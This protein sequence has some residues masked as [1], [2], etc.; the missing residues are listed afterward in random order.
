MVGEI[1]FHLGDCKTGST[2][3]QK[4]LASGVVSCP[5]RS[6]AYPAKNNHNAV[7]TSMY[8][9]SE[10]KDVD[11]RFAELRKRVD[12][13]DADTVVISAEAFEFAA[14]DLMERM[15]ANYF[16]PWQGKIRF[17]SYVRPHSERLVSA[18]AERT[19]QGV[20]LGPMGELLSRF[21]QTG[22]L[23][24]TPRLE[25]WRSR[26]GEAYT[27]RPMIRSQLRDNDVVADFLDYLFEGREFQLGEVSI[28]NESLTIADLAAL[29]KI[30]AIIKQSGGPKLRAAQQ[31]MGWNFAMTLASV[32][33][34]GTTDKPRL[35]R[36][37]AERV[38]EV[39]REDARQLD[40]QFFEG[41]PMTTAL[42][43]APDKALD[44]PQALDAEAFFDAD[45]LR[46]LQGMGQFFGS[47]LSRKPE[48]MRQI[49]RP[50]KPK[51]VGGRTGKD[52]GLIK[53][54]S[55]PSSRA[56]ARTLKG[57]VRSGA[58]KS[59]RALARRLD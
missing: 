50:G 39:Y 19:K 23:H 22:L 52:V 24:Y 18:F 26:F 48:Q 17:I 14:P 21:E 1:V 54:Q 40:E 10:M 59:L 13:C 53:A 31:T 46:V 45:S 33:R 58:R 9:K 27:V 32:P 15:I 57:K 36:E 12:R 35:H 42:E 6:F 3:I 43:I 29:R 20:H 38:R 34:S 56:A 49:M 7:A 55:I 8:R 51:S 44:R 47:M 4:A 2:S 5:E 11:K 30:H 28:A 37:L 25:A 41:T 16:A